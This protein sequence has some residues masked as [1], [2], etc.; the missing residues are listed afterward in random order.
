M[1]LYDNNNQTTTTTG[2][3][4]TYFNNA[5]NNS[6]QLQTSTSTTN[7]TSTT[8]A[9]NTASAT[10]GTT[11]N[12]NK[13]YR[14]RYQNNNNNNQKYYNQYN[15][16]PLNHHQ[17]A[18][19]HHA[20][21]HPYSATLLPPPTYPYHHPHQIHPTTI[22][23]A[24]VNAA[25][26]P[27]PHHFQA[28]SLVQTPKMNQELLETKY[29]PAEFFYQGEKDQLKDQ[30]K[31]FIIKSY[32][33][34]D[35]IHSIKHNLW[36]STE[37]GNAKLNAAFNSTVLDVQTQQ[38]VQP[39]VYLFFSVNGS[40]QFC[41]MAE[42]T[43]QVDFTQKATATDSEKWKGKFDVNWVFIKDIPNAK[44]KHI[45]MPNNEDK[46]VTISRDSQEVL[47][48]Q[49]VEVMNVF[50]TYQ[51]RSSI[52]DDVD[53][54][55][56][57]ISLYKPTVGPHAVPHQHQQQQQQQQTQQAQATTATQRPP[58]S[59]NG[60]TRNNGE[61]R[62]SAAGGNYERSER[63]GAGERQP[64]G[65]FIF[66]FII[67]FSSIDKRSDEPQVLNSYLR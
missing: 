35:V 31:F 21:Y 36:C 13:P 5:S 37:T 14:P 12:A 33:K 27:L 60:S 59:F 58:R 8:A 32:S 64:Y 47:Y 24:P 62:R 34:E 11:Y 51:A 52:L 42:M 67:V 55:L 63:I 9:A 41:G 18:P 43:S 40:G 23:F 38:Q 16:N 65:N 46:P 26:A 48:E 25:G 20:Y 4:Y 30:A 39:A 53:L 17:Y 3:N 10:N 49:A 19:N 66:K 45:I 22:P 50:R 29:N 2:T 1:N 7:V 56:F 54:N 44:F 15:M 28:A 6:N 57:D 61:Q